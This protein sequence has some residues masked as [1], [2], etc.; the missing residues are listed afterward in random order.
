MAD[1]TSR[2]RGFAEASNSC[3]RHRWRLPTACRLRRR[4]GQTS[5]PMR[6]NH[7]HYA[8]TGRR[9][10]NRKGAAGFS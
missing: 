8:P 10:S 4:N 5:N 7:S 2:N 6:R 3:S 1:D 9:C